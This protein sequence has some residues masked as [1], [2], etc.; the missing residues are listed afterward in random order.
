VG[1]EYGRLAG[2]DIG[3]GG[4]RLAAGGVAVV[5]LDGTEWTGDFVGKD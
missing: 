5:E 2:C 4:S 3:G 1:G